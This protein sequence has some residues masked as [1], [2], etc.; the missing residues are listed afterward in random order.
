MRGAILIVLFIA[1]STGLLAAQPPQYK[2]AFTVKVEEAEPVM[3]SA[4]VPPGTSH[5][6]QATQHLRFEIE[7]P[8]TVDSRSVTVV[9]LI[10]DSSGQP[11]TRIHTQRGGPVTLDRAATYTICGN[12]VIAQGPSP[13]QAASCSGL[14]P[15]AAMEPIIGQCGD[16]GGPFEGMPASFTSHVRIAPVGEPGEPITVTGRV[17]DA[18]GKPRSGVIVYAY[19]TDKDGIY[20]PPSPPRSVHSDHQ[21]RLRAWAQSDS[22]GR[23]TFDT[24]RPGS[25]PN[26]DVPQHIH[27]HVVE[28][29]CATYVLDEMVFTDDPKLTPEMLEALSHGFGGNAVV[30]PKRVNGGKGWRVVRDIHLGEKIPGYPGCTSA[31]GTT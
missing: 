30:T 16:C 12:R 5:R 28:R 22:K 26:T 15:M 4:A 17:L 27:M 19:H 6:L 13:T 9:K 29:G 31:H 20:P 11:V 1:V 23:Y 24:I 18:D 14:P 2:F 7:A 10:D 8:A 25:Y 21:G 3:V